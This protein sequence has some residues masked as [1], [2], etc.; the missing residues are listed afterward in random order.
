MSLSLFSDPCEEVSTRSIYSSR[1]GSYN[2][3]WGPTGGSEVVET[4]N[5]I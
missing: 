5:N 2:E 1:P 3:T 4:L